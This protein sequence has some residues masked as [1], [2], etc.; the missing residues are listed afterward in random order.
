MQP[1]LIVLGGFMNN[2]KTSELSDALNEMSVADIDH[3]Y[4]EN[5]INPGTELDKWYDYASDIINEKK[6]KKKEVLIRADIKEKYGYNLLSGQSRI[7]KRRDIIIRIA[8]A[9]NFTLVELNRTLK[10]A[11]FSELYVKDPRDA[12]IYAVFAHRTSDNQ[13][14]KLNEELINHG[15]SKLQEVGKQE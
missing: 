10:L 6:Q 12:F 13:V 11:G 2:I 1:I 7:G 15:F 4:K 8:Y 14:F 3:Y 5:G 9:A